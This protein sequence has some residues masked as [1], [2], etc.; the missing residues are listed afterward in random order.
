M[1]KRSIG[2]GIAHFLLPIRK[3][4]VRFVREFSRDV[5]GCKILEV[6]CGG[7]KDF[8]KFFELQNDVIQ[9][10]LEQHPGCEVLDVTKMSVEEEYDIILAINVIEHVYDYGLAILNMHRALKPGGRLV[11]ST[12]FFY[13]LHDLPDDYW[14]FTTSCLNKILGL[15][16]K[17]E[18]SQSGMKWAPHSV[19]AIATK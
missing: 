1:S 6:G 12:P 7:K 4:Q 15:F 11:L 18:I 19:H 10:D 16:D 9:T 2:R 14:R 17:V 13:P 8:I 5:A 3:A